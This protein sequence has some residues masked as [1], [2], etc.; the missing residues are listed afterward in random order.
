MKLTE[1]VYFYPEK[2]MLDCNTY[3]IS[4]KITTIVD[5]GLEQFL[6]ELIQ[7]MRRDGI[8]PQDIAFIVNTH[9]HLD[10]YWADEALRQQ[11]GAKILLHP[12]QRQFYKITVV[13]T[14]RFFGLSPVEVREDGLLPDRLD[15]G[16]MEF[17]ILPTP[18]HSPDGLCFYCRS[19]GIMICGDLIF[20]HS[21]GRVDLPGGSALELKRSIEE[22]AQLDIEFLLPGHMEYLKGAESVKR[23][24]EF[25]RQQV[26]PWL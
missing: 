26:F 23:N 4:G 5:P 2:G 8:D 12:R 1:G 7:D 24:F 15:L 22:I 16:D 25:V 21:T 13:D 11:S 10:H 20:S 18:G 17:E 9:L 6:P 19:A 14:S 3:I